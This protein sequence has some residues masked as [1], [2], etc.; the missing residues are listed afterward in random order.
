MARVLGVFHGDSKSN[1]EHE[2][3]EALVM[4]IPMLRE[5]FDRRVSKYQ[6][7]LTLRSIK[8]GLVSSQGVFKAVPGLRLNL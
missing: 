4:T 1:R 3:F 7:D 6:G 5:H 8:R 2:R